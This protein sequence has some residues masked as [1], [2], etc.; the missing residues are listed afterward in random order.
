MFWLVGLANKS[1]HFRV[2]RNGFVIQSFPGSTAFALVRVTPTTMWS[3][4]PGASWP[5]R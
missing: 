5:V 2:F 1:L 4:A 3:E